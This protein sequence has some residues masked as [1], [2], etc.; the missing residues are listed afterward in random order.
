MSAFINE[1]LGFLSNF[2]VTVGGVLEALISYIPEV[3]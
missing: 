1:F 3:F 2:G